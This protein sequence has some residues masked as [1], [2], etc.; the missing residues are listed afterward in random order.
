MDISRKKKDRGSCEVFFSKSRL[1]YHLCL[2]LSPHPPST[3]PQERQ[4]AALCGQHCL[5]NLLQR[6]EFSAGVLSD[7]AAGLDARELQVIRD[8]SGPDGKDYRDRL[9]EGSGNVDESGNFSIEV[10]RAA[11]ATHDLALVSFMSEAVKKSGDDL[12]TRS[13]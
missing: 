8:A 6:F 5:N 12:T 11:L 10:L 3:H 13:G 2:T 7:I 4:Q 9:R 1:F